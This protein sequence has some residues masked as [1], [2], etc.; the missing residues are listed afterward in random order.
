[1]VRKDRPIGRS[2]RTRLVGARA[3]VE[4]D[5][6]SVPEQLEGERV[7]MPVAG[8]LVRAEGPVLEQQ[9]VPAIAQD[10]PAGVGEPGV[11]ALVRAG[12]EQIEIEA[13]R[14]RLAGN[15]FRLR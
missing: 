2:L 13:A 8:L 14:Q 6:D 5:G 1:G 11:E 4:N 9:L 12:I 7:R 3:G 15:E 10:G